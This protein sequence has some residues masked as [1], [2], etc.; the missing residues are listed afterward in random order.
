MKSENIRYTM[1]LIP[2]A[3]AAVEAPTNADSEI[4][5]L[6]I[7]QSPNSFHNPTSALRTEYVR[8]PP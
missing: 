7:L 2:V 4:G 5:V 6:M 1:G 8:D 3:A